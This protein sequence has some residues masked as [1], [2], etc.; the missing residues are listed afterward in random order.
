MAYLQITNLA[1]WCA[2]VFEGGPHMQ[3][4]EFFGATVAQQKDSAFRL[5]RAM[6]DGQGSVVAQIRGLF[7]G[8]PPGVDAL[9]LAK[10]IFKGQKGNR[11]ERLYVRTLSAYNAGENE[12]LW[13]HIEVAGSRLAMYL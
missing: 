5:S 12:S 1:G 9:T 7:Q 11:I 6:L 10:S 2:R 8:L 13:A 4:Y 3:V